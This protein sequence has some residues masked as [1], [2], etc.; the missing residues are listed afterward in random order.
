MKDILTEIVALKERMPVDKIYVNA[1][2][3]PTASLRN[4][5]ETSSHGIIAEFK[6]RSPSKGWIKRKANPS[7]IITGYR[8][9]GAAA[10]SVRS[11]E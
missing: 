3:H 2:Y 4:A 8:A 1:C 6:R 10:L 9:S 7:D 5:L 11:D